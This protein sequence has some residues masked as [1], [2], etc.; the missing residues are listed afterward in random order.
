MTEPLPTVPDLD[1]ALYLDQK[2]DPAAP[3]PATLNYT[4]ALSDPPPL[5]PF[6]LP[7]ILSKWDE[8]VSTCQSSL[9]EAET[10]V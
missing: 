9:S 4:M 5:E 8:A 7:L 6:S 10:A 2:G 3:H 1:G